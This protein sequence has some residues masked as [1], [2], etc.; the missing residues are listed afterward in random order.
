MVVGFSDGMVRF[1]GIDEKNFTLIK[2]FKVHKNPII[3][4]KCNREGSIICVTDTAGSIFF[5]SLDSIALNKIVPYCLYETA[6]KINDLSWDKN[7]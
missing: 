5:I 2:A 1:L 7:G 6:F 4:V 3:K